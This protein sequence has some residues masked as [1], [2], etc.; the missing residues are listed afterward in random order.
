MTKPATITSPTH[1][2]GVGAIVA[3][4]VLALQLLAGIAARLG[5]DF[6]R[7]QTED[8]AVLVRCPYGAV[9]SEERG[10]GAF[11]AAETE[12]TVHQ[13]V[14]KPLEADGHFRQPPS[15]SGGHAGRAGKASRMAHAPA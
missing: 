1:A 10:A 6:R 12:G 3:V 2:V 9:F 7:Q 4:G 5:R 8:D 13:A 11:F 15:Q 14:D